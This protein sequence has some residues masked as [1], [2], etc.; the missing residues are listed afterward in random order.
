MNELSYV[1][2]RIL[3]IIPVLFIVTILIF[4]MIR[5][6]PGDPALAMLG[7]KG[8]PAAV[9]AMRHKM[10]LDKS[11][12]VQYFIFLGSL[13]HLDLGS[14]SYYNT[15]VVALIMQKI[16]VTIFLTAVSTVMT[17]IISFPLGYIAGINGDNCKSKIINALS[18]ITISLPS[19]WVGLL[20]L[21]VFGLKLAWFP[22]AG[23]GETWA[24]HFYSMILPG[25]TQALATCSLLIRNIQ[26]SVSNIE[27]KDY[28]DFA[29]SKGLSKKRVRSK[30][31]IKNVLISTVTL[32]S[33]RIA[34][35][36]GGSVVIETVFA[37]PG[38]GSL[39]L[40]G[41]LSRDYAVVQ[42]TVFFFSVIVLAINLIT[43]IS[44]S[45]LDPRVKLQ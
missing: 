7:E 29:Y 19:F 15:P 28:V 22:V 26:N 21:I 13:I 9:E 14:S 16:V 8:S 45:I 11:L 6:I 36:L 34:Y 39:L 41:I 10:G 33:M 40:N 12:V 43:D 1:V 24:E 31:V 38:M 18:L 4:V 27:K 30:Y 23:W 42:G 5:M 32:L 20:L 3:Q 25:F 44:Y 37:L 17:L 2:K 35:M